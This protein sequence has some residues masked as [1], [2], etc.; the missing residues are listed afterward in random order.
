MAELTG[1]LPDVS[2]SGLPAGAD[3]RVSVNFSSLGRAVGNFLDD[4]AKE[5]EAKEKADI[6]ADTVNQQ[7][8]ATTNFLQNGEDLD[9]SE[10][11]RL[12]IF[13]A[14]QD[15]QRQAALANPN[16]KS[17]IDKLD[18]I[19]QARTQAKSPDQIE[20]YY[21]QAA[22]ITKR[23]L[24]DHP[25]YGD[26]VLKASQ[27]ALGFDPLEKAVGLEQAQAIKQQD[28]EQAQVKMLADKALNAGVGIPGESQESLV[29]K[30]QALAQQEYILDQQKKQA[31]LIQAT[32]PDE[33]EL[34][35]TKFAGFVKSMGPRF[36]SDIASFGSSML[37]LAPE[38]RNDPQS[39]AKLQQAW[40]DRRR[41]F[42]A[43][44]EPYILSI[45]DPSVQEDARKALDASLAPYDS[46]W[47]GSFSEIENKTR[48][49]DL[50]NKQEG[51]D[52][53]VAAP[54]VSRLNRLSGPLAD[55]VLN[56]VYLTNPEF[57]K[58]FTDQ[59]I[60]FATTGQTTGTQHDLQNFTSFVEGSVPL[61]T[62]NPDDA[63]TTIRLATAGLAKLSESPNTLKQNDLQSYS[64]MALQLAA[65]AANKPISADQLAA[66]TKTVSS[67]SMLRLFER[68]SE[69][70]NSD[71]A[72]VQALAQGIQAVNLKNINT[73]IALMKQSGEQRQYVEPRSG[74]EMVP[75]G[76]YD[77]QFN[78]VI[79]KFELNVE[80]SSSV[81]SREV[82][83]RLDSINQSLDALTT[84][85]DKIGGRASELNDAQLRQYV[86]SSNGFPTKGTPTDLPDWTK[87]Q[88]KPAAEPPSTEDL[89]NQ[90]VSLGQAGDKASIETLLKTLTG[91]QQA[92]PTP[93][94]DKVEQPLQ[95]Q[96]D[97]SSMATQAADAIG[98]DPNLVLKVIKQESGGKADAVSSVGALGLMQL[99]PDT[100]KDLGVDPNDPAQN[101]QGGVTYLKQQLDRFGG[102]QR[103]ALAA[104]NWGPAN[105]QR[106]I[107]KWGDQWDQHLP[108]ETENYI[109]S[110]LGS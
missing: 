62:M 91:G 101:I 77:I 9:A 95:L 61:E 97:V 74:V 38:L 23:I 30:G 6:F 7:T 78:P 19:R 80:G 46:T 69:D 28:F 13:A 103:K 94:P 106:A 11:A 24:N 60:K 79:G 56:K 63:K 75:A 110:I 109:K 57:N 70:P 35:R 14:G 3:S 43:S 26:I 44:M 73:Q 21:L 53:A 4:R 87:E 15:D 89:V 2:S 41:A 66:A 104:Y 37:D 8:A 5:K 86:V 18:R 68:Y 47:T 10:Q 72:R 17:A 29:R 92:A 27:A 31:D 83:R 1:N 65:V 25:Q 85:Q 105:L 88:A 76:K 42:V 67:P 102:D 48:Q 16:V 45:D 71:Q 82:Y 51:I 100:A 39:Q 64:T 58:T 59:T 34:K 90:L 12:D 32:K 55:A 52:L 20:R 96:G 50:L 98:V 108:D 107:D 33:A 36:A 49:L 54:L 81:V 84:T 99:M 93:L 22:D 40:G